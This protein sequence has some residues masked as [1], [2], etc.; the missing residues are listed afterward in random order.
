MLLLT[1]RL[2]IFGLRLRK[3]RNNKSCS[4]LIVDGC[5]DDISIA[6]LFALKYRSLYTSVPFDRIEMQTILNELDAKMQYERVCQSDQCFT[7]YEVGAAIKKLK[8]HKNDGSGNGLS[9]DHFLFAGLDH[10]VPY[11]IFVH[12]YGYTWVCS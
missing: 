6:N 9:T 11:C 3:I 12:L 1:I 10:V 4:S 5:S 2:V 8:A 7:S